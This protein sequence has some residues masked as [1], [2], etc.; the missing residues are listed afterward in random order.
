MYK[1]LKVKVSSDVDV[2]GTCSQGDIST[3]YNDLVDTFGSQVVKIR[4]KLMSN[5]IYYLQ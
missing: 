2:N 4:I 1:I 3:N 5:G